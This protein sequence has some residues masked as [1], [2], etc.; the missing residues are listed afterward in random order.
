[1]IR[2]IEDTWK[3]IDFTRKAFN[4]VQ[5]SILMFFE[6]NKRIHLCKNRYLLPLWM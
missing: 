3:K 4:L 1:M 5:C 6:E 2:I